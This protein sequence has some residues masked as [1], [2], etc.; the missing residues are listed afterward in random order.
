MK[1]FKQKYILLFTTIMVLF[2]GCSQSPKTPKYAESPMLLSWILYEN[3]T[4]DDKYDLWDIY[5]E[6][7]PEIFDILG[8]PNLD[9]SDFDF[10]FACMYI[11]QDIV[12]QYFSKKGHFSET[13]LQFQLFYIE[14]LRDNWD[15]KYSNLFS[16]GID[17][18]KT[19][20]RI[21]HICDGFKLFITTISEEGVK[22][23]KWKEI[24]QENGIYLV[25][26]N[27]EPTNSYVLVQLTEPGNTWSASII[28]TNKTE[29]EI[30][31][32]FEEKK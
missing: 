21:E 11:T 22:M 17:Q 27:I 4:E 29:A 6:K 18:E 14:C 13:D 31:T 9:N 3:I 28:Q 10:S 20:E 16:S 26:Y 5:E 30:E 8:F 32:Y 7:I 12:S 15:N 2:F 25:S 24:S 19:K 23:H 1:L